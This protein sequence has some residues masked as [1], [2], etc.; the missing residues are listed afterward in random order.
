MSW[1]VLSNLRHNGVEYKAGQ[2]IHDLS[3]EAA[4]ELTALKVVEPQ[5]AA[6][7]G[8]DVHTVEHQGQQLVND[9]KVDAETVEGQAEEDIKATLAQNEQLKNTPG[10]PVNKGASAG[11][12]TAE[13]I[14]ADAASVA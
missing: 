10:T 3:E 7:V 5:V 14:A 4:A 9:A 2:V 6:Q 8:N 1:N 12:P 13:Q 11:Q